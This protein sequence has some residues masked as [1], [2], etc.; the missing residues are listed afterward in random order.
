MAAP[1]RESEA[2]RSLCCCPDRQVVRETE[3]GSRMMIDCPL[4][5]PAAKL[6]TQASYEARSGAPPAEAPPQSRLGISYTASTG[7]CPAAAAGVVTALTSLVTV[8]GL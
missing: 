7:T 4:P 5:S 3:S 1:A 2:N 8:E 6:R